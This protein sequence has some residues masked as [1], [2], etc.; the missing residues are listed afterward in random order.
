ML[1]ELPELV[2]DVLPVLPL[3]Y[4]FISWA[5]GVVIAM[6]A[7]HDAVI[8]DSRSCDAANNAAPLALQFFKLHQLP[9]FWRSSK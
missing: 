2:S 3:R 5:F 1:D 4:Y 9:P 8:I 7:V 6:N